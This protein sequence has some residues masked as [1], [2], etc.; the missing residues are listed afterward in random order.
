MPRKATETA[1]APRYLSVQAAALHLGYSPRQMARMR[2][3][4]RGPAYVRAGARVTYDLRD[5]DRWASAQKV[6][7]TPRKAAQLEEART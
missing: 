2:S 4:G 6:H 1:Q 5:L 7:P 3:E